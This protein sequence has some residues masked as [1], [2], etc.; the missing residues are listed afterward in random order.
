MTRP[1]SSFVTGATGF[2]GHYVVASLLRLGKSCVA[3]VR[4][5]DGGPQKLKGLLRGAG[6]SSGELSQL[7]FAVGELPDG[8][9]AKLDHPVDQIIH[10]AASTQFHAAN[11]EPQRT[12]VAG[13]RRLL[14]W[15]D[16]QGIAD[17]TLV[18]TAYVCGAT[19]ERVAER[20][21]RVA[22]QFHNDYERSKWEAEQL[23]AS[24]ASHG[25]RR[26]LIVRPSIVAGEYTSG[27]ATGFRGFYPVARAIEQLSR[28]LEDAAPAERHSVRLRMPGEAE[29]EN[30]LVPVDFVG[31][32][33]AWLA[34]DQSASGVYHLT[35]PAP[36]T[37]GQIKSWLEEIFDVRGGQFVGSLPIPASAQSS[38]EQVFFGAL[39]SLTA[40]FADAPKFDSSRAQAALAPAGI[41]CPTL[42][43]AYAERCVRWAQSQRWGRASRTSD[44][45]GIERF[46]AAYFERFLPAHLPDSTVARVKPV[47]ATVRFIVGEGQWLCRF[48]G[49]RLIRLGHG[50]DEAEDFGYRT[51]AEG[52]WRAIGGRT[53]G[54]ELF[55]GGQADVFGDVE[56]ALKM[57]VILGEFTREF[58]CDRSRLSGYMEHA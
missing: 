38:Y 4:D 10:V 7:S 58:P 25:P 11:D 21:E 14:A 23:A 47:R 37:N 17:F 36:P 56:R 18:S 53:E 30:S 52:F 1:A 57:S 51:T 2:V 40:Y 45:N 46:G 12:N 43:D 6:V 22:P 8:L 32:A 33:I 49:G 29:R 48:D 19:T 28:S 15:A 13:T 27:R 31:R 39:N 16:E 41:H 50:A 54:E 44:G 55:L 35:H 3:L 9:P 34:S 42:D 26:L 20:L 24:W 5:T